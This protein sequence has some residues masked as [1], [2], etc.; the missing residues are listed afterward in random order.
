[1]E[2][3]SLTFRDPARHIDGIL[4]VTGAGATGGCTTCHG[5]GESSAP[6]R[7]LSGDTAPTVSGVGAHAAHLKSSTWHRAVT[8]SNCHVVPTA[9]DSPGHRDGDNLAEVIFDTL[10]PAGTYTAATTTCASQYCHSNGRGNTGTVS[11]VVP[12]ALA[13]TSCHSVD[14]TNMSNNHRRHLG[15]GMNCNGCHRDVVDQ[16]RTIINAT[17][18]VNGVHEVKMAAGAYNAATKSCTNTGCHGTE[19]W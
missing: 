19:R 15:E 10:N 5:S 7:D 2:E 14:G 18:H 13:C 11:W 17:L 9:L 12:G 16:N 3:G 4:D 1:M 6:P 8:C